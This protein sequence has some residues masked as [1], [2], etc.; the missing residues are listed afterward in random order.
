MREI[1]LEVRQ[2]DHHAVVRAAGSLGKDAAEQVGMMMI[3]CLN[4]G[5]THV[6]LDMAAVPYINSDGLRMLQEVLRQAETRDASLALASPND[7][8]LRTLTLTRMDKALPIF[9]SVEEA[10]RNKT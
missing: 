6:V 1:D 7:N 10:L 4:E 9:A 2:F 3:S 8:V 5:D